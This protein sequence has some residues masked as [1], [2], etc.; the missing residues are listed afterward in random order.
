MLIL[1]LLQIIKK[2][3]GFPPVFL[4]S[5]PCFQTL[6]NWDQASYKDCHFRANREIHFENDSIL[7]RVNQTVADHKFRPHP[8]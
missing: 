7:Q 6:Q 3:G 4:L 8:A 5:F 1:I 2:T